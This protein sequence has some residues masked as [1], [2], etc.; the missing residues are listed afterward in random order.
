MR[1]GQR[2]AGT[3]VGGVRS[4]GGGVTAVRLFFWCLLLA[5]MLA[6]TVIYLT[7]PVG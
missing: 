2:T 3:R 6:A 4:G 7:L 1:S 5:F